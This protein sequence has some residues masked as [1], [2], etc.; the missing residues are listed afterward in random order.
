MR[1]REFLPLA[2]GAANHKF[3]PA[4]AQSETAAQLAKRWVAET[5][6][7]GLTIAPHTGDGAAAVEQLEIVTA[8]RVSRA[9]FAWVRAQNE[10]AHG[11]HGKVA[12]AGVSSAA[13]RICTVIFCRGSS[14]RKFW[15]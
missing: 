3:A 1:R 2:G 15:C 5:R 9:K 6:E 8:E 10:R 14:Q 7:T 11:V 12:R 4:Y 13:T